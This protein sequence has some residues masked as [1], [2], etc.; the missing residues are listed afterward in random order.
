MSTVATAGKT[1][2]GVSGWMR[3]QISYNA[4]E[5]ILQIKTDGPLELQTLGQYFTSVGEAM[6]RFGCKHALVD[7]RKSNLSLNPVEIYN[8]P[9]LLSEHGIQGHKAAI[10]FNRLGEDERFAEIVCK[11]RGVRIKLFTDPLAA[12]AWLNADD[13]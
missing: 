4:T 5:S 7:H 10:L 13:S 6:A 11:N 9:R 12:I 1:I 3:W 2:C 8:I